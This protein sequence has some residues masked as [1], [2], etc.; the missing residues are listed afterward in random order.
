MADEN[1][2]KVSTRASYQ[3]LAQVAA[4][5]SVA[6]SLA[7]VAY[8]LKQARDIALAELTL[9]VH[10]R[11]G[12]RNLYL[13]DPAAFN[14]AT[15]KLVMGLEEEMTEA[16]FTSFHRVASHDM[17]VQESLFLLYQLGL[18]PS[19]EW[20]AQRD[21]TKLML[22]RSSIS[23]NIIANP[24]LMLRPEFRDEMLGILEEAQAE[25]AADPSKAEWRW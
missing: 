12:A 13:A 14:A 16:E 6:L 20:Q 10:E 2:E 9:S 8:E 11:Q 17:A 4:A 5:L 19:E 15:A 18:L 7:F 22:Q 21:F 23:R 3:W 24:T 25:I 1:T